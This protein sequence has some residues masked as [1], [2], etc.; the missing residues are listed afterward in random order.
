MRYDKEKCPLCQQPF[1]EEDDV[2]VCPE[3]GTPQHR[4][5]YNEAGKCVNSHLHETGFTW[6]KASEEKAEVSEESVENTDE[7]DKEETIE[8]PE[9]GTEVKKSNF[10][11]PNC[12]AITKP[13]IERQFM[14]QA[15]D[16]VYFEGKAV[17][18]NEFIDD[19][20]TVTVKEAVCLVQRNKDS[21]IK[22]FL[23]A[24][25]ENKRPKFNFAAFFFG[26]YWLFFRKMYKPGF[27]F[28]GINFALSLFLSSFSY[29]ISLSPSFS[30]YETVL[31]QMMELFSSYS[32]ASREQL[33]QAQAQ[34]TEAVN[35]C[36][37]ALYTCFQQNLTNFIWMFV[38]I[39]I[40]LLVNVFIG[41]FANRFYLNHIKTTVPKIKQ[42][43]PSES[44]YYT[45]LYAKGGVSFLA[46]LLISMALRYLLGFIIS[47]I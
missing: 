45:Y 4:S 9:C 20:N 42:L 39:G 3:C 28:A 5:C 2:V 19:E 14:P 46:P 32:D 31:Q 43:V 41:F 12:G 40:M 21:Y 34:L 25:K 17:N 6:E 1:T 44:A 8:C 7:Q 24:K 36:Y 38:V 16:T 33:M 27:A 22:T 47:F 30:A 37:D 11:C 10:L 23:K 15:S 18:G 13:E 26:Y 29:T 35:V